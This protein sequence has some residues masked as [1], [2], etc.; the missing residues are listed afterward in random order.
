MGKLFRV[1]F[2]V[3]GI[4]GMLATAGAGYIYATNSELVGEFWAVKDDFKAV[5]AERREEV[6]AELPARIT[7]EREVRQD[8]SELPDDRQA[9]LYSQ[10]TKSRDSVFEQFKQRIHAEAEIARKAKEAKQ[11]VAEVSKTIERELGKVDVGVDL[12][13]RARAPKVDNLAGVSAA[14]GDVSRARLS[15]GEAIDR[16]GDRVA[17]AVSVL[18]ALDRLGDEVQAA[19]RKELSSYEQDRLTDVVTDAKATLYDVK[20]TPGLSSDP[21]AMKLLQSVP[22]KLNR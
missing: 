9:E 17:P 8:M 19:R 2:A 1:L 14:R 21:T 16:G 10:L 13:P 7:F 11:S 20:Q 4:I 5:P 15:Y 18:T 3:F 22:A 12:T 6:I